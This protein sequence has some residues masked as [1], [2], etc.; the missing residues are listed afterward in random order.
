MPITHQNIDL[1]DAPVHI[2]AHQVNGRGVMGAGLATHIKQHFPHVFAS[3]VRYCHGRPPASLLG[4]NLIVCANGRPG[5]F[6][7]GTGQ[8]VANLFG[9]A[10]TSRTEKMTDEN[11]VRTALTHLRDFAK[12]RNL[13]VALPHHMGCN[14]GGGDWRVIEA[15]IADVFADYPVLI[16][17][18]P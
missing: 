1:F 14:L 15:I 16:C 2:I 18:K 5:A 6:Y 7:D 11:A 10:M 9:Q 17:R 8:L 13:S 4:Q 12:A 3:Y